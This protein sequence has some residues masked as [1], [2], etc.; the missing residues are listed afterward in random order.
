MHNLALELAHQ[1]HQVTGSDDEIYEP[2]RS[3]LSAAGLLPNKM[4]WIVANIS[5]DIDYVILGMHARKDNPELAR[6]IELNL[7]VVS[8]PEFIYECSKNKK[9]LVVA[10]SHGKT[11][12][13]SMIMHVLKNLEYN[14][15]YL[16]GAQLDGFD[17]MVRLTEAP[18][19]VLEGDEYLSSPIDRR[20]KMLHYHP[21]VCVVTGI[22]WDHINVYPSYEGYKDQFGFLLNDMDNGSKA[23]LYYD[24][25]ELQLLGKEKYDT[26][27]EYYN[28]LTVNDNGEVVYEGDI[29]KISIF[30]KH[31]LA[32]MS[33]A[34]KVC[35]E[36]GIDGKAFLRSISSFTGAS[37]RLQLEYDVDDLAIYRD[38][39]H[40]P[41][42][43]R[44]T[45]EA[46]AEEYIGRKMIAILELHTFSSLNSAFLPQY[47]GVL[48]AADKAIVYYDAHTL[49]MKRMPMLD[50]ME[51]M[52][53][54]G[55]ENLV[56]E[57]APEKLTDL[58]QKLDPRG[59]VILIMSSGK[60]GGV[61]I[62]EIILNK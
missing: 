35:G 21:D 10:G 18:I 28:P 27:V 41:S 22:A 60:M 23:I 36:V 3:R 39:A 1:G 2:S 56:V 9:R 8:Y 61:D 11:T 51:V 6:S 38:F 48:K 19:M 40:A 43:V 47:K 12:T 46:V 34:L 33:A 49:V 62:Q 24:D 4:G 26:E 37:N 29:F 7:K 44:A 15:D 32:N 13:T 16:V 57:N 50:K 45:V 54:F 14:F 59:A 42:K 55:T 52:K 20:P 17:R 53:A 25:D 30:G 58:V 5:D 31:N